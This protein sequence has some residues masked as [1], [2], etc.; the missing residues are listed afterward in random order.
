MPTFKNIWLID[1]FRTNLWL[2]LSQQMGL[3]VT[4]LTWKWTNSHSRH[5]ESDCDLVRLSL[6][7]YKSDVGASWDQV[8]HISTV[9]GTYWAQITSNWFS[10]SVTGGALV[11][12]IG[13]IQ[14]VS[15]TRFS[16]RDEFSTEVSS[17]PTQ[18]D[19]VMKTCKTL[20]RLSVIEK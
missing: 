3:P 13:V 5:S 6:P 10:Y 8:G 1:K 9:T 19:S 20:N 16:Q 4:A 11:Y 18:T 15:F 7:V 17:P 12:R 14:H 2:V